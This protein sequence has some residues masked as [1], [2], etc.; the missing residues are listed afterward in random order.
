[1]TFICELDAMVWDHLVNLA[2]LVALG[3]GMPYEDDQTWL[4]HLCLNEQVLERGLRNQEK[5]RHRN[6]G[7]YVLRSCSVFG[8]LTIPSHT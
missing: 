4:D 8:L 5:V 7:V 2:V 6:E 3:L 1:M